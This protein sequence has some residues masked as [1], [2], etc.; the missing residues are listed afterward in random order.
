MQ[1]ERTLQTTLRIDTVI[2]DSQ[3][4]VYLYL[5]VVHCYACCSSVLTIPVQIRGPQ[6][7]ERVAVPKTRDLSQI[8]APCLWLFFFLTFFPTKSSYYKD[9]E[10]C[11]PG[12]C[13]SRGYF[14]IFECVFCSHDL[15]AAFFCCYLLH[16]I[17]CLFC[18]LSSNLCRN[19]Q[20]G[21]AV[22]C[23]Y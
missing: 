8:V 15:V 14:H 21:F 18:F 10:S 7:K 20:H 16:D 3:K 11:V 2:N 19:D 1:L 4:R 23:F 12:N 5:R 9:C 13:L 6:V 22:V 17:G